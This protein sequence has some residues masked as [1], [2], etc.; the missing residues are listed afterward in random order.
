M[1]RF[2]MLSPQFSHDIS[3]TVNQ[4]PKDFI[5]DFFTKKNDISFYIDDDVI[6]GIQDINDG[7][8]KFLWTLESIHFNNGCFD[9][10]KNN[11]EDVLNTFELIFTYNEELLNLSN[12]MIW[13]PAMG[14]WVKDPK[15]H[16]KTKL[17]SMITSR[18]VLTPQQIFRVNYA[19]SVKDKIDVYG[20]GFNEISSK[21]DGLN[22]YMFSI[23]IENTT[24]DSYFTEKILDCFATGT[25]PIYKG[26][27]KILNHFDG[28]GILFLDDIEL[29]D[30]TPELYYSK[31]NNIEN[32]FKLVNEYLLPEDKIFK[33]I[34]ENI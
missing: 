24:F 12:K 26:T 11:L 25:I 27:K 10:I 15:I 6:R 23:C 1:K 33:F 2:N 32:N 3:S 14:S 21:E 18:K 31:K 22:D 28:G 34:K 17:V 13:I 7:K 5:W 29:T 9:F 4:K 16:D 20:R 30:L 8:R 19:E